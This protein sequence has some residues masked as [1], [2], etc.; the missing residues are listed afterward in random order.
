VVLDAKNHRGIAAGA[1]PKSRI[2][3]GTTHRIWKQS[4][5]VGERILY[6][7]AFPLIRKGQDS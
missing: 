4:F 5:T 6:Q 1:V 7:V 3:Y 2:L